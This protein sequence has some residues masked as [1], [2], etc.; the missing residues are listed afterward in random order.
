M[1]AAIEKLIKAVIRFFFG[2]IK[3]LGN[4]AATSPKQTM[5]EV[6]VIPDASAAEITSSD[7]PPPLAVE[8]PLI[9]VECTSCG[10]LGQ[11][12][13][14][15]QKCQRPVCSRDFCKKDVYVKELDMLVIHCRNCASTT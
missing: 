3:E 8:R 14:I 7:E 4:Y 2:L 1:I 12:T 13:R 11:L 10:S 15:C 5:T 6:A 9:L